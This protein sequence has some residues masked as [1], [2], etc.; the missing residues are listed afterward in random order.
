VLIGFLLGLLVGFL[1]GVSQ[2]DR[3]IVVPLGQ[4]IRT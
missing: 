4:G 3:T 2:C 1:V